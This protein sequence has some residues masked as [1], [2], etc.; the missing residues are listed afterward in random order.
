[1]TIKN[2]VIGLYVNGNDGTN[3]VNATLNNVQIYNC[4]NIGLYATTGY[5]SGKNVVINNCG[6]AS[7]QGSFGGS[8]EFTHCTFANYWENPNQTC[9]I[10]DDYIETNEGNIVE[11]LVKADFI[12][13][14]VY[15]S[16]NLGISHKKEGSI[17]NFKYTNCLIKFIDTNNQFINVDE[18]DFNDVT[19]F[20]DC[21]RASTS[22]TNKPDFF[23]PN[24]NK[25]II[26]EES[27]AINVGLNLSPNFNDILNKPRPTNSNPKPDMGAYNFIIFE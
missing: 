9:I 17:F 22:A 1:L 8:Y 21:I 4:S 10:L 26:G 13:C 15:G 6:Q 27:A 24:D 12:N 5:V 2:A 23:E 3:S 11:E 18:Y 14:I 19:H 16:S 20:V 25:L 7:F